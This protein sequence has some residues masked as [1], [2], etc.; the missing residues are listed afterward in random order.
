MIVNHIGVIPALHKCLRLAKG[1]ATPRCPPFCPIDDDISM[2]FRVRVGVALRVSQLSSRSITSR[3]QQPTNG[4]RGEDIADDHYYA[5]YLALVLVW[6]AFI[7]WCP[8]WHE[9]AA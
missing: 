7:E 4:R 6:R 5:I 8:I 1:S 9:K 3:T 2:I